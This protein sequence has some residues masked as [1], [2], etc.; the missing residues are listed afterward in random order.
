MRTKF[1]LQNNIKIMGN[2]NK[3]LQAPQVEDEEKHVNGDLNP[4]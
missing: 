3:Y 4:I 1:A 2:S